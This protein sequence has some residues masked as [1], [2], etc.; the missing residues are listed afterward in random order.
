MKKLCPE[1]VLKGP[2]LLHGYRWIIASHGYANIVPSSSDHICG[3]IYEIS[4]KDEKK[5][6]IYE[7]IKNGLYRKEY[8]EVQGF[9]LP[10]SPALVYISQDI[11]EGKAKKT[12]L[13]MIQ[14]GIA[15]AKFP[16]TYVN[17]YISPFMSRCGLI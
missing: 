4:D 15:E 12:Y 13:R 6:D 16:S 5:L 11:A 9:G 17:R 8:L 14:E 1:H 10:K 2:G 3:L 7:D